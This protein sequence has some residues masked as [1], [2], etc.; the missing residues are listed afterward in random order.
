MSRL[1]LI[2]NSYQHGLGYLDHCEQQLLALYGPA[3]RR[4][5]FVGYAGSDLAA[6]AEGA[7]ER[8]QRMGYQLDAV[9]DAADPAAAVREAEAIFIGGGNTFR[10][11][12]A[13][14]EK[15]L[16][17]AI[18]GR[19]S[20]G[21]PYG[22][23]SAG[24]NVACVSIRTTNDMPIVQ[25]PSFDAL[26]LVPFNINPHYVDPE[27]SSRHLG[28]TREQRIREF[29]EENWPPVVGLREGAMLRIED[30]SMQLA[31][32]NGARLFERG[33]EPREL[34]TGEPLDY[35]L[36]PGHL[37]SDRRS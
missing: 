22:G 10:L 25:P 16:V 33:R 8:F 18:R 20:T 19:V 28:E 17:D 31:G 21:M 4:V 6:Y 35:L 29:H 9:Q 23:A 32:V 12:K 3:I 2:S 15:G 34:A 27:P 24:S 11:L 36:Q 37:R 5:L 7:R 26:D 14:Y 1:L 13:L 30:G